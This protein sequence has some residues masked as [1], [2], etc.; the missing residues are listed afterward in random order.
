MACIQG[1]MRRGG[2]SRRASSEAAARILVSFL[3][4]VMLTHRSLAREFSP[5]D[6]F[7]GTRIA[8]GS[9]KWCPRGWR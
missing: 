1:K 7:R 3:S 8:R 4:L 5:D 6:Q 9:R 2:T